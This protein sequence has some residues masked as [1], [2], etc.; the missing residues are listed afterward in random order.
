MYLHTYHEN[1]AILQLFF[2][3]TKH[4]GIFDVPFIIF[5]Q[6]DSIVLI[7]QNLFKWLYIVVSIC[8]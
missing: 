4:L 5:W 7:T 6:L 3:L 2:H 8:S 1:H